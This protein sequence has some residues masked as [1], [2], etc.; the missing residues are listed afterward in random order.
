MCSL[1]GYVFFVIFD[2]GLNILFF[3][4]KCFLLC[5]REFDGRVGGFFLKDVNLKIL[6]LL[7]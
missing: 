5:V 7:E 6:E 3:G 2:F 4:F 1:V